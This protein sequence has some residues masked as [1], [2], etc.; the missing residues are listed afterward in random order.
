MRTPPRAGS[1]FQRLP[2]KRPEPRFVKYTGACKRGYG[3]GPVLFRCMINMRLPLWNRVV[4]RATD[5]QPRGKSLARTAEERAPRKMYRAWQST[6]VI[7]DEGEGVRVDRC[8][9]RSGWQPPE[10]LIHVRGRA[11]FLERRRAAGRA[12]SP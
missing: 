4:T 2:R 7:V 1:D 6:V 8:S 12:L 9:A 3:A 10:L 11:G 5:S